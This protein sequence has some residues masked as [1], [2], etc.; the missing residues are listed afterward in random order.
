MNALSKLFEVLHLSR[1]EMT[2]RRS[3]RRRRAR[4]H[5]SALSCETLEPK[6]LLAADVAVQFS[7]LVLDTTDPTIVAIEGKFQEDTVSGNVVK[8][9]TN[10]PVSD[11][12]IYIELTS[13]T[14]LTNANFLSYVDSNAYDNTFFHRSVNNFVLQGG[15]F[16]APTVP[17][18]QPLSDPL[19]ITTTGTVQNEPGNPNVRGTIA[20]AK[21]GGD[22]DSA[23]SQFFFN[24][25]D[26][27][28]DSLGN[29]G[30]FLDSD[31]GGYTVFGEVLGSGMTAIDLMNNALTYD[32]SAYYANTGLDEL[33][34][35]N[36]ND[37]NIVQPNDFLVIENADEVTESDLMT[38]VVSSSDAAKLTA[39]FDGN[40]DLV[41]TPNASASGSVTVTVTATSKLDNSTAS[42]TFSV[43]L[44]GPV[45]P[46]FTAIETAGDTTLNKDQDGK[47]YAGDQPLYMSGTT[48]LTETYFASYTP[49]AVEDFGAGNKRFVLKH[50]TGS[51]LTFTMSSTWTRTGNLPWIETNDPT[52]F[53]TAEADYGVDFNNDGVTGR[54]LTALESTGTALNK[55]QNGKLYAGDQPL[56]MSGTTQ[57]TET[58]FASY[59]PVAVEDFGAGDKRFVLKHSTG[60]LLTFT[61]SSTWTRT[62]NLPWIET[63]DPTAFNTA[64]ADYGVDFNNDGVTG[65]I[66]TALES[67]GTALNKDQNGKLYAGDQP[68][69]MSG[70]TQ[71]TE[72]YFASYTPVAVEDFGAG[73]KRFVLKHST[74]SLLT[75]SMSSTW[76]R[77]GNLPWIETND[78]TAFNTAEADYGVDFDGDGDV[79][80]I[81]LETNGLELKKDLSG[82]LYADDKPLYMSGTTQ[83]TET[84]FASYT[85]VAVEDFGEGDKRFVLK[86]S[87]GS[88]LTFSMSSTWTRTGNLPW[89]ETNDPT[90]FNTAEADY[91]VDFDGDGDV[92]L[93]ELETNGLELKKDLSGK[94]YADDKPLYMSGTTQ[95]TETY[96]AS[97]TPVAVED[98]GEGDK[99]F[100]LKHSTGSLLTFSMS[101]TWTRTGNLPWI[102]TDDPTGFNAAELEY[103]VDFDNDGN[104]GLIFTPIETAGSTALRRDQSGRLYAG[105]QPIYLSGTTQLT[106][107][108]FAAYTPVA[109][110]DFGEG[111]KRFV[112][113][114]STGSLLTFTM[115]ATWTRTGNLPW[116]EVDDS[117]A[118]NAAE[119]EY[120]LD[121]DGDA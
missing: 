120:G 47:L 92:S 61:M 72:T 35:Y 40:G 107:T 74:G 119:A 116:I 49:V 6:Q 5:G 104:T 23:T 112:L 21:L 83:L 2:L 103:G 1:G 88:L 76:T 4:R 70:T 43:Q 53:N 78:P 11:S 85:P 41:L 27:N 18:D 17:A 39:S 60:S 46:L 95:L 30:G 82:K 25:S 62:G 108:Y 90:A 117:A 34:L 36:R 55:D 42:D 8:F 63:N 93:I 75:F 105:S 81:E 22:P 89:I 33:P 44:G 111:D 100:V 91:G 96:F 52:A 86:H 13:N 115:S 48:Q 59:T 97:Y 98:F 9:D 54:I 110:E 99:R 71:L 102:E 94:L 113:K 16:S 51:L 50:S 118:F 38:Y 45:A 15:G 73:N 121:F 69:Y 32:A 12:N 19:P 65:R 101:S 66:L 67:T 106:E 28:L 10:A 3:H 114:H 26:N 29:P 80:L 24:I 20:M 109:V 37:D 58:Y 77:T 84:Y 31:N 87:T 14:P 68:L 79:S 57:L 64:E 56:Y 7:D